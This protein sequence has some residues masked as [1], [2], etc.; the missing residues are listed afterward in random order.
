MATADPLPPTALQSVAE[1]LG[2]FLAGPPAAAPHALAAVKKPELAESL[3]VC[4]VT[5][6]QVVDGRRP[7]E[8]R[9]HRP[10]D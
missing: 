4:V 1:Q 3:V 8:R 5:A 6:A 10:D 7:S 2:Q 9:G